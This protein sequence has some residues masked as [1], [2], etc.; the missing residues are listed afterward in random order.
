MS[1]NYIAA[2]YFIVIAGL[3]D[4]ID[5]KIARIMGI[6]TN[7][8][9]G[10]ASFRKCITI[11]LNMESTKNLKLDDNLYFVEDDYVHQPNS[12]K[13]YFLDSCND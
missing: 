1:K 3:F 6:P 4:S 12:D 10:A 9:N 2:S 5:G 7:F 13:F 11:A 8:G